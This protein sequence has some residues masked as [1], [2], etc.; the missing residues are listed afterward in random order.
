MNSKNKNFRGMGLVEMLIAIAIFTMGIGGFSI[1]FQRSWQTNSYIYETGQDVFLASRAVNLIVSDLRRAKQADN[2]D[3]LFKSGDDFDLIIYIDIDKDGDVE[4]VHYYLELDDDQL[5][6]GVSEP[7]S[8]N[9]PTYSSGDDSTT[10]LASHIVNSS[11]QPVFSYY[12]NNYLSDSNPF[13]TPI[14]YEDID[15]IRLIKVH[16]WADTRPYHSPDYTNIESFAQ[17]RN[18]ID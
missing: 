16:L 15:N 4:K 14:D 9:P 17:I 10:V 5:I 7:S 13:E 18:L 1:L 6:R 8:D 3:Y 12:S 11:S 2:G